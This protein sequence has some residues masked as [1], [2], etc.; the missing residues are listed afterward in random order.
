MLNAS[1]F[2]VPSGLAAAS[3]SSYFPAG[4]V[5][6]DAILDSGETTQSG[7]IPSSL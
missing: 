3:L 2:Q 6:N 7:L 5:V 1:Q 4:R